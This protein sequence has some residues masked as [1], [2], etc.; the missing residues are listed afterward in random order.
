MI[1]ASDWLMDFEC[2]YN[3]IVLILT[4]TR[5]QQFLL[6]SRLASFCFGPEMIV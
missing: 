6:R 2:R 3:V 4:V 5:C 1:L